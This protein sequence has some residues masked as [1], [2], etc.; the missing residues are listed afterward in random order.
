MMHL[1]REEAAAKLFVQQ[2]IQL[3]PVAMTCDQSTDEQSAR[4][5]ASLFMHDIAD[6]TL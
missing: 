1:G 2:S 5:R 4:L 3:G 6:I